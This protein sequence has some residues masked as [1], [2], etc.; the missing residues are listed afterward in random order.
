MGWFQGVPGSHA[1]L[2]SSWPRSPHW[3]CFLRHAPCPSHQ[4]TRTAAVLWQQHP[5]QHRNKLWP[6]TLCVRVLCAPPRQPHL[7][8]WTC[9]LTRPCCCQGP[10]S[11]KQP[12]PPP[13]P[14]HTHLH[15]S[16]CDTSTAARLPAWSEHQ[17]QFSAPAAA[18]AAGGNSLLSSQPAAAHAQPAHPACRQLSYVVL[19]GT[20]ACRVMN[21]VQ[22]DCVSKWCGCCCHVG[23]GL[24]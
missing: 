15:L 7:L 1:A 22:M 8:L 16:D 9:L 11:R 20:A 3:L 21:R 10:P 17:T 4:H 6:F 24:I 13:A 5:Q 18:Q 12:H 19:D 2:H 23:F 14:P